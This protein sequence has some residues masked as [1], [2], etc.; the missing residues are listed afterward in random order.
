VP[1]PSLSGPSASSAPTDPRYWTISAA[2]AA[3]RRGE[4]TPAERNE[5]VAALRQRRLHARARAAR[6]YREGRIGIDELLD[7]QRAID[8]RI[9][10]W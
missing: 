3:A 5:I 1:A 7:A 4:I 6:A 9:E 8:R 2:K 10:G